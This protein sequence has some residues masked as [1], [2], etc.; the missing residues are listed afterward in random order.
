ML[1]KEPA[2]GVSTSL[3]LILILSLASASQPDITKLLDLATF[4][5]AGP[6]DESYVLASGGNETNGLN[7][8]FFT[9]NGSRGS[10]G[11][12]GLMASPCFTIEFK[13]FSSS[14]TVDEDCAGTCATTCTGY[15]E[16]ANMDCIG[17]SWCDC[18][19]RTTSGCGTCGTNAVTNCGDVPDSGACQNSYETSSGYTCMS[20]QPQGFPTYCQIYS[21]AHCSSCFLS[22]TKII[23]IDA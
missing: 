19:C 14:C 21:D 2:L 13:V 18:W 7:E 16:I 4:G 1:N 6:I 10:G 5:V 8:F 17:S 22:G 20:M 15:D 23:T 11:D 12:L 3:T 9:D